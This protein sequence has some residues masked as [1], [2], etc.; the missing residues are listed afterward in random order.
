V[1]LLPE[2]RE[3]VATH[4]ERE[5]L[6]GQLMLA[7]H[8][9]GRTAE[10]LVVHDEL[11]R[12]LERRLGVDPGDELVA[13]ERA[14]RRD[15]PTLG[16]PTPLFLPAPAGRFIGRQRELDE[17]AG[18]LGRT[19]LL[20]LVGPGGCGKTRLA[21]ELAGRALSD[22]PDGV[23]FVD[24]TPAADAASVT[25]SV[26]AGLALRPRPGEPLAATLATHL[27]DRRLLLVL[28]NCE[29]VPAAAAGLGL[30]LLEACPGLRVLATSRQPLGLAG[31]TVWRVPSMALPATGAAPSDAAESDAV[32]LLADR[33]GSVL[34]G[35]ELGG[36][37]A[38]Q[39]AAV[40]Q[41]LDALPLA[42][43]LVAGRLPSLSLSEVRAHLDRRL[44][45]LV[46][47]GAGPRSRHQTM[48]AA[49]DWSHDLLEPAERALFRRLSVFAGRFDLTAAEEVAAG[50]GQEPPA[51][52]GEV[53]PL[54]LRLV[55]KSMVVAERL[56]S[57][58][59]GYRLLET[60]R[61]YAAAR[62]QEADEAAAARTRHAQWC[63]S[64]AESTGAYAGVEQEAMVTRLDPE[65][66]NVR[67]ALRWCLEERRAPEQ[68][69]AIAA[70]LW[71]YWWVRGAGD[72]GRAWLSRCLAAGDEAPTAARGLGLRAA[73]AL[74]RN[75]G[76]LVDALRL[77]EE[78]LAAYRALDDPVGVAAAL[79]GLCITAC[80]HR[81]YETALRY[82]G[83]SLERAIAAGSRYGE[84]NSLNN[85]GVVLRSLDRLGE[86]EAALDRALQGARE[87]GNRRLEGGALSNLA[88]VA[89]Q[90]GDMA[91]ARER[92]LASLSVYDG[93]QF[94]EGV[95]DALRTIA[96]VE[97]AEGRPESGLQLL[98]VM[99]RE[100]E[101][102]GVPVLN[103]EEREMEEST[104]TAASEALT[105]DRRDAVL[106]QAR[107]TAL[108]AVTAAL[109]AHPAPSPE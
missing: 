16:A 77:G 86:A 67:A 85:L 19:R 26:A 88:L 53:L 39:A 79:N 105:A 23:H 12:T 52:A 65:L 34:P 99:A 38:L 75:S 91:R 100:R 87:T 71:W 46:S 83:A 109:L 17:T 103:S 72:E 7:L 78:S 48:G 102:V 32:R 62:L 1:E 80:Y 55:D 42:I 106:A 70:P 96:A 97:V 93:L 66:S 20:T 21:I 35:Y 43:E 8:R 73:A 29:H 60:I 6:T 9:S 76:D 92:A 5:R 58:T 2:L 94:L 54:L 27:R 47:A 61:D 81:D 33:A 18:L 44:A 98:A 63:R 45:L 59:T 68:A 95:L 89:H 108:D 57:G 14:I 104:R 49:I 28:D 24:L 107:R 50:P 90:G 74:A 82:A 10:A 25:R 101:L 15:D 69:L 11:C 30:E 56:A 41:R 31:E 51:A 13:L 37:D 4:P 64:L 84:T 3:L 36:D 22:H 40:C